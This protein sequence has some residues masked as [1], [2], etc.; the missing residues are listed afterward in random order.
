MEGSLKVP[1]HTEI[2][3]GLADFCWFEHKFLARG[4]L[5]KLTSQ[6]PHTSFLLPVSVRVQ[7]ALK[8]E[9]PA[10]TFNSIV[11]RINKSSSSSLYCSE[12]NETNEVMKLFKYLWHKLYGS[13]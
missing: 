9:V 1:V 7:A 3:D 4:D 2:H 8:P 12:C 6:K 11:S 10:H 5:D 13:Q